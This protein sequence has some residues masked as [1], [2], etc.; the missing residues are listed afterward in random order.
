MIKPQDADYHVKPDTHWQWAET[1]FFPVQVAGTSL[2]GGIYVLARPKLDV[3]MSS[4]TFMDRLTFLWED[5]AYIDNQQHLQCPK[6]L[7]DFTL[8][9][10]LSV[11]AVEP[12][13]HYRV[14]Y[15]GIDD[16]RFDLDYVALHAPFD[17]NDPAMDPIAARRNGATSWDNAFAGHYEVTYRIRGELVLRGKRNEVDAVDTGDRSW[18]PRAERDN[19]CFIWWHA[20]FGEDLTVHILTGH[21]FPNS[22]Q[23]GALISGYVLENGQTY[24]LTECRGVQDY[25]KGLPLG[26]QLE[27][28]DIRGKTFGFTYSALNACYMAPYPSNTYLQTFMRVNHNGKIGTGVQQFGLSRAYS[29]RHREEILSRY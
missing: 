4:I 14:K 29:T 12:L 3:A 20:S 22:N 9:N 28:T 5:Q 21:D 2:N 25:M 13:M 19:A 6:S 18:G 24:G 11:K 8:T 16:T 23:I 26:G 7:L 17:L 10:G 15:E 27:V 1:L